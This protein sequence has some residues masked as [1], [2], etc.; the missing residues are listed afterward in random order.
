MTFDHLSQQNYFR[1]I[2]SKATFIIKH[3][4]VVF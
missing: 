4:I 1:P 2:E 3:R